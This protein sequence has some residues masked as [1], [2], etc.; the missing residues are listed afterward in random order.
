MKIQDN[1]TGLHYISIPTADLDETI[2][3]YTE[4]GFDITLMTEHPVTG[5]QIVFMKQQDLL[6]KAYEDETVT[7]ENTAIQFAIRVLD[8][9][10]AYDFICKRGLSVM[11]DAVQSLPY[12]EN[13]LR[14]FT[15]EGP[16][17]E[18]VEFT[19]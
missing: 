9:E 10:D 18:R 19:A 8:I 7:A 1:I 14:Y 11:E 17:K 2:L 12:F 3:F 16:N 6:L 15:V 4:I 13:G 5:R